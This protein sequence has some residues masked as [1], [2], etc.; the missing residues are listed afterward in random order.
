M[1]QNRADH[2]GL[3]TC[4]P[5]RNFHLPPRGLVG[6]L[7]RAQIARQ[8][9][10]AG[11]CSPSETRTSQLDVF[12]VV[13]ASSPA[14]AIIP[15]HTLGGVAERLNAPV[16]KTGRPSGVSWVRIPS[17]PLTGA[18]SRQLSAISRRTCHRDGPTAARVLDHRTPGGCCDRGAAHR[19][20]HSGARRGASG[21]GEGRTR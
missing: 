15:A 18:V 3:S 11:R 17:P 16:L 4:R 13:V 10:S 8:G 7:T 2:A 1:T 20:P 9:L 6:S 19:P 14:T 12:S 5:A 21:G